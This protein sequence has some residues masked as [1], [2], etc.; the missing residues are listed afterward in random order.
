MPKNAPQVK[1]PEMSRAFDYVYKDINELLRA[2]N[3]VSSKVNR[4]ESKG[5]DGDLRLYRDLRTKQYFLEG[6]FND[7]W[8]QVELSTSLKKNTVGS[9]GG[10]SGVQSDWNQSN[11]GSDDFIKN[12]GWLN[13]KNKGKMR[14]EGKDYIVKDGDVLNFRF[15]T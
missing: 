2:V 8:A 1:D 10:G 13:S 6:R 11:S 15:N 4:Q 3:G 5:T 12:K 14:L 9:T 7:G